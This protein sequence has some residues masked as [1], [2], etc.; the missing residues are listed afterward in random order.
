MTHDELIERSRLYLMERSGTPDRSETSY[1]ALV[2]A[3]T[4]ERARLEA[5]L[6]Y[7]IFAVYDSSVTL[8][9]PAEPVK[10]KIQDTRDPYR[11]RGPEH[12]GCPPHMLIATLVEWAESAFSMEIAEG[13]LVGCEILFHEATTEQL[14]TLAA[15]IKAA[16]LWAVDSYRSPHEGRST[17]ARAYVLANDAACG[18]R[19]ARAVLQLHSQPTRVRLDRA[20]EIIQHVRVG[21]RTY[22]LPQDYSE[23]LSLLSLQ[24]ITEIN[25]TPVY[26]DL[27]CMLQKLQALRER[28]Y[29]RKNQLVFGDDRVYWNLPPYQAI[30]R[31]LDLQPGWC[32]GSG[33]LPMH[34]ILHELAPW[35]LLNGE[36][37]FPMLTG[38]LWLQW[39]IGPFEVEC[40]ICNEEDWE[41]VR[42]ELSVFDLNG[43]SLA[44]ELEEKKV[45]PFDVAVL[46]KELKLIREL[47][48]EGKYNS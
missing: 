10:L 17:E 24:W 35:L 41:E 43:R 11:L 6:R 23:L 31:L 22:K 38:G 44:L 12:V 8:W 46:E 30:R 37:I 34:R 1:R 20:D 33:V 48:S 16:V 21:N 9:E 36:R 14:H 19:S 25:G 47:G 7:P 39:S 15:P 4:P 28:R 32:G 13:E 5:Q 3:T 40:R 45:F 2:L 42:M 18:E 26:R 29:T 27:R